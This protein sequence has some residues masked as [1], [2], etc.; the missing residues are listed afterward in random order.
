MVSHNHG[1]LSSCLCCFRVPLAQRSRNL[2]TCA[3]GCYPRYSESPRRSFGLTLRKVY[4][5]VQDRENTSGIA[6]ANQVSLVSRG[7]VTLKRCYTFYGGTEL[8]MF[9]ADAAHG[10]CRSLFGNRKQLLQSI[11]KALVFV[12]NISIVRVLRAIT[13]SNKT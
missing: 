13:I 2:F 12:V 1:T 5:W 10:F 8:Q 11:A 9:T 6:R 4:H 7:T 3:E